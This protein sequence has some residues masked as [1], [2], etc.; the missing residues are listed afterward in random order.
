MCTLRGIWILKEHSTGA[1]VVFSKR[2]N[3][4]EVRVRLMSGSNYQPIPSDNDLLRLFY[5]DVIFPQQQLLH[6]QSAQN[7]AGSIAAQQQAKAAAA[8]L[9]PGQPKPVPPPA[10]QQQQQPH[11]NISTASLKL[12]DSTPNTHVISLNQDRIWPLIYIKKKNFY[13]LTIPVINEYLTNNVKPSFIELPQITASVTFL[14]EVAFFTQS[15]LAKPPPYPELQVYFANI[16]PFGQPTDSNFNNIKT[17]IKSGFPSNEV[18]TPRR[19]AWRPFLHKGK[20]QLDFIISET[21]QVIQYDSQTVPDQIKVFG[22]LFCKAE[23]EG[24]PEVSA[25]ITTPQPTTSTQQPTTVSSSSSSTQSNNN[26]ISIT[27]MSIDSTVQ[28]TSDVAITNKI[29]FTPPLDNFRVLTYGVSGVKTIPIRGFYQMK[30]ITPT[31]VKILVQL[32][33][34]DQMQNS[35]D[36]CLMRIPLSGR[37]NIVTVNASPTTGSIHID[38][39]LRA[40]IWNIGQK[41]SGRNLEVALPAE[42]AFGP[43]TNPPI[44]PTLSVTGSSGNQSNTAYPNQSFPITEQSQGDDDDRDPFCYNSNTFV[45]LF[46][47]LQHC[48][49]SG[50]NIDPKKVSIYPASKSKINVDR[51]IVSSEYIIWNSL[52][53]NVKSSYQPPNVSNIQSTLSSST[54]TG[55]TTTTNSSL[56]SSSIISNE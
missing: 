27:H 11:N 22:S 21:V 48:T 23:L 44:T 8:T 10:T 56:S 54:T 20:Q 35:F 36:Y 17:M 46:F 7:M 33:L 15:F 37:G 52:S 50:F 2:I 16:I 53:E 43:I 28:T 5:F 34:N 26:D 49:L 55:F 12:Y 40:I 9:Q 18:F 3:T 6:Q 47:K 38:M 13:F 45:K 51:E 41:F 4:V 1:D 19:P 24:Q 39:N 31:L 30:E 32:K 25:Y 42:I 14:E 29:T